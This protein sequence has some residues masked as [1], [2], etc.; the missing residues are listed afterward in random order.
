M[1]RFITKKW[2]EVHDQSEETHNT[3]EQ[4]RFKT[5]MLRSDLCDYSDAYI[6]VKE[7][8]LLQIQIMMHMTRN[9]LL[10]IMHH[11]FLAF[12]KLIIHLLIMQKIYM[13]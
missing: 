1:P 5:S 11:F 6:I 3:N 2:I 12:Q 10:R 9:E 7:K 13:L 8:L 4:I